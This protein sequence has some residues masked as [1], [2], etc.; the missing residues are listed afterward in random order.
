MGPPAGSV[1]YPWQNASFADPN[2]GPK[3]PAPS[4]GLPHHKREPRRDLASSCAFT[5]VHNAARDRRFASGS[6]HTRVSRARAWRRPHPAASP[7]PLAPRSRGSGPGLLRLE[8]QH[9]QP[10][11]A[12]PRQLGPAA[13]GPAALG[14]AARAAQPA[15][16]ARPH[17]ALH[18]QGPLAAAGRAG[19]PRALLRALLRRALRGVQQ[20]QGAQLRHTVR[21][22][23]LPPPSRARPHRPAHTRP[24][25][26]SH[27]PWNREG[28]SQR[29]AHRTSP[30]RTAPHR[31]APHRTA[32]PAPS[33]RAAAPLPGTPSSRSRQRPR[34]TTTMWAAPR[35]APR[36]RAATAAARG[37][38]AAAAAAE[39]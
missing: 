15:P 24:N 6:T 11:Q 27:M 20:V 5:H 23:C 29:R 28:P 14:A 38:A 16:L 31:T 30:H 17:A 34:L 9:L 1:P 33:L 39:G 3:G 22:A 37:R 35:W 19:E 25:A 26:P 18:L 32:P 13:Q 7:S 12:A 4:F 8:H 2:K 21:G 10:A 36:P